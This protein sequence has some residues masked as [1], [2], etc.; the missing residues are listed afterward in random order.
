MTRSSRTLDAPRF[1]S[2][3]L[4]ALALATGCGDNLSYTP[5]VEGDGAADGATVLECIPDLDGRIGSAELVPA[6]GAAVD[7]LASAAG[8]A[9][10]VDVTGSV[11]AEGRRRWNLSV[12]ASTDRTVSLRASSL[13]G[14]WFAGSFPR[15]TFAAPLDVDASLQG[16]YSHDD[17]ALWLHGVASTEEAPTEG[18]TLLVYEFAIPLYRFPLEV[19]KAWSAVGVISAGTLRGLPYVGTDHYEITDD[20]SGMLLLQNVVFTQVHRLR[21]NVRLEPSAGV[22]TTTRQVGFVFECFG[23]VARLT[24]VRDE[25]ADDFTMASEV[26]RLAF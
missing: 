2:L 24:S 18:E 6:I 22:V 9:R 8:E 21:T 25:P 15:G 19:G 5:T 7:Y 16:I 1:A 10:K 20:A 11:D 17:E 12:E 13:V 3:A 23:E 14:K 26:R 4:S